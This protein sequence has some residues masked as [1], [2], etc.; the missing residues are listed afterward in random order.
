MTFDIVSNT[1]DKAVEVDPGS[2]AGMTIVFYESEQLSSV[3]RRWVKNEI[4]ALRSQ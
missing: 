4:A 1:L 3:G 2:W